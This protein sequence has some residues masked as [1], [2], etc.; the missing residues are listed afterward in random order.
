MLRQRW[1]KQSE[2]EAQWKKETLASAGEKDWFGFKTKLSSLSNNLS[3]LIDAVDRNTAA[4]NKEDSSGRSSKNLPSKK[5]RGGK[6]AQQ[7]TRQE[8]EDKDT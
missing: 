1:A 2:K 5:R 3:T 7:D 8:F 4:I 6:K